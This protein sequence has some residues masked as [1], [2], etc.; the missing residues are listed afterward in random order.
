MLLSKE[1]GRSVHSAKLVKCRAKERRRCFECRLYLIV[2]TDK[3]S[4]QCR[5]RSEPGV[6]SEYTLFTIQ[7]AF[8][9]Q[10]NMKKT[11]LFKRGHNYVLRPSTPTFD[12]LPWQ[13]SQ[14]LYVYIQSLTSE[15]GSRLFDSV[16]RALDFYPDSPVRIPRKAEIFFS[17]ASFLCYDFHVIRW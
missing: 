3:Q 15:S 8:W 17:Y 2:Y 12:Y 10:V 7:S 5:P 6:C 9:T 16:V 1:R 11:E 14:S 13:I 4:I